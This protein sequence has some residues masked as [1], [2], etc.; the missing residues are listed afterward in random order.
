MG[1]AEGNAETLNTHKQNGEWKMNINEAMVISFVTSLTDR[2]L[3]ESEIGSLLGFVKAV[4]N[5]YSNAE[6]ETL[7]DAMKN[8]R[9]IDAIKSYRA[10]TG[11][12]LI[13]AKNAV[14]RH[15]VSNVEKLS[16]VQT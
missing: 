15:F 5:S 11:A 1:R 9:K 10:M 16:N 2:M 8:S 14:E 6:L 7:M 13:D 12:P 3:S 4:S